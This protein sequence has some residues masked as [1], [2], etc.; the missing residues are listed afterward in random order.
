MHKRIPTFTLTYNYI[1]CV[2]SAE[3]REIFK[4]AKTHRIQAYKRQKVQ[5]N[6][7]RTKH[8]MRIFEEV[9]FIKVQNHGSI[10][11]VSLMREF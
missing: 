7:V 9:H 6:A 11:L 10:L 3:V 5:K 8:N 4:I 2:D 1:H